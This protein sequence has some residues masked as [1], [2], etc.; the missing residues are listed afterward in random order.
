LRVGIIVK[1]IFDTPALTAV[2]TAVVV[3]STENLKAA[4]RP[5][6]KFVVRVAEHVPVTCNW[7]LLAKPVGRAPCA[8]A[9][10]GALLGP[11]APLVKAMQFPQPVVSKGKQVKRFKVEQ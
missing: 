7:A 6:L 10:Q 4:A 8:I 1:V 11:M 2:H 9:T 3:R 5:V